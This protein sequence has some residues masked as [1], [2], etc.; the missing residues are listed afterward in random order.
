M[1][2]RYYDGW[3][4]DHYV[5]GVY[6]FCPDGTIPIA[7]FNVPG[8]FHDS[9]VCEY[10]GIYDKLDT[11]WKRCNG[12]CIV[13]SVFSQKKIEYL[14]KLLQQYFKSVDPNDFI[15][16]KDTTSMRQSAEWGMQSSQGS[17]PHLK[18]HFLWEENG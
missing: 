16:N 13:D 11:I 8:S 7:I 4:Y 2:M 14:I 5:T 3:T 15:T 6:C 1:Q 12:K 9:N 18:D 17:F 10:G